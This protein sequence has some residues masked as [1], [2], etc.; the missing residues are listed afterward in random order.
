MIDA[1]SRIKGMKRIT[2]EPY[3]V[4]IEKEES[5]DWR[6]ILPESEKIVIQHLKKN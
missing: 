2:P 4:T 1:L 3:E 6:E 5:F